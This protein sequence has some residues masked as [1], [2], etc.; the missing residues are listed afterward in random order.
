LYAFLIAPC[1]LHAR[2]IS[3]FLARSP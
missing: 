2:P 1:V 3:S